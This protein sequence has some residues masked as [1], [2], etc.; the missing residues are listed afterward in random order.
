LTGNIGNEIKNDSITSSNYIKKENLSG[1]LFEQ[2][3]AGKISDN[4]VNSINDITINA[5][6]LKTANDLKISE[7]NKEGK[8]ANNIVSGLDNRNYELKPIVHSVSGEVYEKSEFKEQLVEGSVYSDIKPKTGEVD[9]L[10]EIDNKS[11]TIKHDLKNENILSEVSNKNGY[12]DEI[13]NLNDY[14]PNKRDSLE[15]Q[16]IYDENDIEIKK[17][18]NLGTLLYDTKVGTNSSF[19]N[20]FIFMF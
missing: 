4:V 9:T 3:D 1:V 16:K 7:I 14:S 6:K 2:D 12:T 13:G 18:T 11:E 20:S 19:D 5:G 15:N 10:G 17:E 8:S